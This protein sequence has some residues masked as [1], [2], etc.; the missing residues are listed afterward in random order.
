MK[1]QTAIQIDVTAGGSTNK[2]EPEY[3]RQWTVT[4][5]D[6]ESAHR[7]KRISETVNAAFQYAKSLVKNS[8]LRW[9]SVDWRWLQ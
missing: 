9:I 4:N 8:D 3:S 6:Y 5:R 7:G 2:P 1:P